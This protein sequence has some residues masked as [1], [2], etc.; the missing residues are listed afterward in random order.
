MIGKRLRTLRQRAGLSQLELAK[1]LNM[2]NQNVSNYEREFRQPD[3][4]TL[5]KFADF[6]EVTTDY[7]LG[8]SNDPLFTKL[9][10]SRGDTRLEKIIKMIE[11][12]PEEKQEILWIKLEAF[13]EGMSTADKKE[14]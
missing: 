4:E 2:P 7:I 9:E 1:K 14:D 3:Y 10:D 8:R 12:I 5:L 6:F 11:D 13:V